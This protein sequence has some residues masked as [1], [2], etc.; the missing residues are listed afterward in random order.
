MYIICESKIVEMSGYMFWE[1]EIAVYD[2][3][4]DSHIIKN[5]MKV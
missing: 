5:K 3:I 4:K 1:R 2:L